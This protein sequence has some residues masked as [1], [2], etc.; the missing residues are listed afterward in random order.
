MI[1]YVKIFY[2]HFYL[3]YRYIHIHYYIHY[4]YHYHNNH[5]YYLGDPY[6]KVIDDNVKKVYI[7]DEYIYTKNDKM[8]DKWY[9]EECLKIFTE[10]GASAKTVDRAELKKLINEKEKESK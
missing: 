5:F 7:E 1:H 10:R 9:K 8:L 6:T 4:H 2:L 3:Y